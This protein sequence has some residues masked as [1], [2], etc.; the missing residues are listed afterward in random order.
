[1]VHCW[2]ETNLSLLQGEGGLEAAV[3]ESMGKTAHSVWKLV[4]LGPVSGSL[5][6]GDHNFSARNQL[7]RRPRINAFFL[8]IIF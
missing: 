6:A 8:F 5:A 1:M 3:S 4:R 7:D 2:Q